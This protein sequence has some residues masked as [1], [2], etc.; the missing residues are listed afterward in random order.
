[1]PYDAMRGDRPKQ[2]RP[3][4]LQRRILVL[5]GRYPSHEGDVS[6]GGVARL[7]AAIH[8]RGYAITVVVPS[9]GRFHGRRMQEGIESVH[10]GYIWE[11]L[12]PTHTGIPG[13]R[14]GG[15][16]R[17]LL[18]WS[19]L[20][21]L[22]VAFAAKGAREL[23]NAEVVY[24]HGL[25]PAVAAA[26]VSKL[27]AT[28]LIVSFGGEDELRAR[29]RKTWRRLFRWVTGRARA[30]VPMSEEFRTAVKAWGVPEAKCHPL[31]FGVDTD[32]FHPAQSVPGFADGI[33]LLFVGSLTRRK[34][35][36]DL[37]DALDDPGLSNVKLTVAGDGPYASVLK[38]MAGLLGLDARI[39]WRGA[40]PQA[41][42]ARTMRS[43]HIL[44][45]PSYM[46]GRPRVI[47]EAMASALPVIVGRT[48]G[49]PDM[50][51]EG[52]T[53]LLFE[54]GDVQGLREC[55]KTLVD[56]PDLGIKMGNAGYDLFMRSE[57]HWD[58][59][60]EELDTLFQCII[61]EDW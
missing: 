29:D 43:S 26:V 23:C 16:C 14:P 2:Q 38:E 5:T 46:E 9:D 37:L 25:L 32:V 6:G 17:S 12:L 45:L 39:D 8:R 24:A 13:D 10:F 15:I 1:M 20:L 47:G 28:P 54:P 57:D 42:V 44:C 40:M 11:R 52:E 31:S 56:A 61:E 36:Q 30:V 3:N 7:L 22:M 4:T 48:G 55:I 35:L 51:R 58:E 50:V 59:A 34:G 21:I 19:N 18:G 49:I 60:A 41:E 33:R 53:G 27:T